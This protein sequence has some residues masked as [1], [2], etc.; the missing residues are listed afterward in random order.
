MGD[1][2][3]G[4]GDGDDAAR[5]RAVTVT[6]QSGSAIPTGPAG[7]VLGGSYPT[8]TFA[9]NGTTPIMGT[10]TNLLGAN[11]PMANANQFY[12]GPAVAVTAGTWLVVATTIGVGGT[13]AQTYLSAKLWDGTTVISS[14]MG[15]APASGIPI[16]VVCVGTYVATGTATVKLSAAFNTAGGTLLAAASPNGAGNNACILTALRIA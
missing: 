4:D 8:P 7:G 10:L 1:C 13:A 16:E 2:G 14:T 5:D 15:A 3:D 11:V 6:N 9:T 12:D